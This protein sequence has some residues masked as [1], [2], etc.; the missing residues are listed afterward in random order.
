[1][2]TKFVQFIF[3]LLFPQIPCKIK[4]ETKSW[5]L[6]EKLLVWLQMV[7]TNNASNFHRWFMVTPS[8]CHFDTP[9]ILYPKCA[10]PHTWSLAQSTSNK[11]EKWTYF[12]PF[13]DTVYKLKNRERKIKFDLWWDNLEKYSRLHRVQKRV[14]LTLVLIWPNFE[15]F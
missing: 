10:P 7:P 13:V 1:M 5:I 8:G 4:I 3:Q 9:Q 12:E 6:Q 14:G 11:A 15:N 2:I